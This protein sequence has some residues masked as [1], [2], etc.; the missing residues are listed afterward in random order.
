MNDPRARLELAT[1]V[2]DAIMRRLQAA[3]LRLPSGA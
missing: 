3:G 2:G 1:H